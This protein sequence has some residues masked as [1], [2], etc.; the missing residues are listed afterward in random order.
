[1]ESPHRRASGIPIPKS[2]MALKKHMSKSSDDL[3]GDSSYVDHN[4]SG[5]LDLFTLLEE[6][7]ALKE[8]TENLLSQKNSRMFNCILIASIF[9]RFWLI[10]R[11][12]RR[13]PHFMHTVWC[14]CVCV[15]CLLFSDSKKCSFGTREQSFE[16]STERNNRPAKSTE[17]PIANAND[18]ISKR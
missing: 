6:N 13:L 15:Y 2:K 5:D 14:V 9:A 18:E 4:T 17:G 16:Q 11:N 10:V 8:R 12:A 7:I 1:M 3:L